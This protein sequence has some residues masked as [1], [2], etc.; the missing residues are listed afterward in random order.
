MNIYDVRHKIN[1]QEWLNNNIFY[2]LLLFILFE[3]IIFFITLFVVRS[4]DEIYSNARYRSRYS[5][6]Y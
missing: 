6:R 3:I 1:Y 5:V 2:K 4:N